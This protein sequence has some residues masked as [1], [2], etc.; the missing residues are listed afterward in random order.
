MANEEN[1]EAEEAKEELSPEEAAAKSKKKKL[2]IIIAAALLVLGGGAG[3]FVFLSGGDSKMSAKPTTEG[4]EATGEGETAEAAKPDGEGAETADKPAEGD[5]AAKDGAKPDE[6]KGDDDKKVA[7]NI[8]F[9]CTHSFEPFHLNL[10][11]P[12]ENRYIRLQL[13]IEYGCAEEIEAEIKK[14]LPQ[15]RDAVISVTSQKTR[16]ALLSPDGK[17]QLTREIHNRINNYM[18]NKVD[19]VFVTDILIE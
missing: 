3:A 10:G 4:G 12:L 8:D 2:I 13:A 18:T 16:E 7:E 14:R 1:K 9:G 17:T 5:E 6:K 19:N 15:L 11:N